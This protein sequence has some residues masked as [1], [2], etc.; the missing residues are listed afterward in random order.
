MLSEHGLVKLNEALHNNTK[1][2]IR[3]YMDFIAEHNFGAELIRYNSGSGVSIAYEPDSFKRPPDFVINKNGVF[4]YIQMKKLSDSEREN[5]QRKIIDSIKRA[6]YKI[7]VG[8]F[9]SLNLSEDFNAKDADL[10]LS[11]LSES[12]AY[13][14]ENID[15]QF[16][17]TGRPKIIFSLYPPNKI[18]LQHLTVGTSGNLEWIETTG[19]AEKQV[20]NSLSK[21]IGAFSWNSGEKAINI[22]AMEADRYDDIDISQ[23]VF[24]TE[25]FLV[26][27]N[28]SKAWARDEDGFFNNP[29]HSPKICAVIAL[30]RTSHTL[31]SR[32]KKTL[33]I[34]ERFLEIVDQVKSV[35]DI[36]EILT[37]KDLPKD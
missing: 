25:K 14:P 19:E 35:V 5:K 29:N 23:A 1:N 24:G 21:A 33:F 6:F 11:F 30:R 3:N 28:G 34:N 20:K 31:I 4:F 12:I 7:T 2:N 13:L 27:S 37:T 18:E 36:D 10:F 17:P 26:Y 9:V 32:Y 16:P 8:K 15:L 22:I